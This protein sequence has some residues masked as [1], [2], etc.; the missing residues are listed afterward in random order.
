MQTAIDLYRH[1][2][3]TWTHIFLKQGQHFVSNGKPARVKAVLGSCLSVTMHCPIMKMGGIT[4]SILPFPIPGSR[5]ATE[6]RGRFVIL[7]VRDLLDR[8][9]SL[10]A[11]KNSLEVSVF[12]GGQMLLHDPAK[13]VLKP[14]DIGRK[15]VET[16][17]K[18]IRELGLSVTDTDVGGLLGRKIIFFPQSGDVQV[19]KTNRLV[20]QA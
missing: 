15:N 14:L 18:S 20:K 19:E 8:M 9:L 11:I 2:F 1:E 16:A 6:H 10:G 13:R 12:G 5:S 7:S 4:H 3:D 17:F